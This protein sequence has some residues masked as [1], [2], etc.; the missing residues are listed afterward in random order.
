M[1]KIR[2][3]FDVKS[4]YNNIFC[5]KETLIK[6]GKMDQTLDLDAF[7]PR[8]LHDS[9]ALQYDSTVQSAWLKMF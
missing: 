9:L 7:P 3:Q 6:P 2:K 5:V 1:R 8:A 4:R